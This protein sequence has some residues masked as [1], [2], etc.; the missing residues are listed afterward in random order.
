MCKGMTMKVHADVPV[1]KSLWQQKCK[2]NGV[3]ADCECERDAHQAADSA[4]NMH[5]GA[6]R[7][8]MQ[9]S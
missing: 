4:R 6:C 3:A 9:R 1:E 8:I 7:I 2:K 5:D